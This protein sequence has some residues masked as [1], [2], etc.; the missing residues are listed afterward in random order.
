MISF[1]CVLTVA[2][3]RPTPAWDPHHHPAPIHPLAGLENCYLWICTEATGDYLWALSP[4]FFQGQKPV[5]TDVQAELD[6][7]TRKQ[8]S[9]V[10]ANNIPPPTEN[11]AWRQQKQLHRPLRKYSGK[12]HVHVSIKKQLTKFPMSI[13]VSTH[14]GFTK[15]SFRCY[16]I[17]WCSGEMGRERYERMEVLMR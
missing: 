15:T 8:D 10:S 13:S 7:M 9:M 12:I 14:N 2:A 17:F 3:S 4:V 6:R 11:E 5:L 1:A 16:Q